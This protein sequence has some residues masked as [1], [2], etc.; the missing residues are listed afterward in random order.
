MIL[1]IEA[2]KLKTL[3]DVE[4]FMAAHG[5]GEAAPPGRAAAYAHIGKTMARFTYWKQGRAAKGLLRRYP[6]LTTGLSASQLTRLIARYLAEGVVEGLGA[7]AGMPAA[8]APADTDGPKGA[9]PGGILRA[10][11]VGPG[12]SGRFAS[13]PPRPRRVDQ[14]MTFIPNCR[15]R[16]LPAPPI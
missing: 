14:K 11:P 13:R 12:F 8:E 5:A 4:A 3:A 2:G 15:F 10:R 6:L 9:V 7:D 16:G 1:Q